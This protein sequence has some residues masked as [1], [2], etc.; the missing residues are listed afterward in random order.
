M[1]VDIAN[2][3]PRFQKV[4]AQTEKWSVV[5]RSRLLS[6]LKGELSLPRCL[7]DI[8]VLRR[9]GALSEAELRLIFL[10]ARGHHLSTLLSGAT[11]MLYFLFTFI[12][13]NFRSLY[14]I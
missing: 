13:Y 7:V 4:A 11:G 2:G 6:E 1:E 10:Q 3:F 12:T 5:L 8:G 14:F 9:M